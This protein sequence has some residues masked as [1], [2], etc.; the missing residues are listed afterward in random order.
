VST[1][2]EEIRRRDVN[3]SPPLRVTVVGGGV[4]GLTCALELAR[5]GLRVAVLTA[6]P[7]EDTTSAVAAALWFP[8]RAAP[9]DAVLRWSATSLTAFTEL[10]MDDA[11]GVALMPGTVVHRT[12]EPDLWWTPAVPNHRPALSTEIPPGA[13]AGTRCTLPVV[14]MGRYLPWLVQACRDAEVTVTA[15]RVSRLSAVAGDAVVVAAGLGSGPLVD[16]HTGVPIQGQVVRLADPG[17][18][19]WLLDEENPA[20]LTYVVPRGHD[21]VCGGTA[22]DGATGTAPDPDVERAVLERAYALVPELRAAEV[23]SRAVG[24]RP[25]R[26]TVR[27]DRTVV[28]GRPVISCY[29]HGGAGVTLSWGCAADVVALA[30]GSP[31]C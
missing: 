13:S 7:V 11:T 27:L 28:D 20:G 17:L 23:R 5:A 19:G 8:Y 10:A 9:A 22:V 1:G 3:A 4:V 15:T 12:A 31:A 30:T 29:G 21:V 24:L 16:D 2:A 18:T 6:D 25:G 26:P 14:D